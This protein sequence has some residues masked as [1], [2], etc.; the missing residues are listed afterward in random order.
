MFVKF[1]LKN[2]VLIDGKEGSGKT[3]FCREFIDNFLN[4]GWNVSLLAY[5]DYHEGDVVEFGERYE[6]KADLVV[7]VS[8]E[9]KE[10]ILD[11]LLSEQKQRLDIL[12]KRGVMR[13][14]LQIAVFDECGYFEGE[15][16][17]KLIKVLQNADICNQIILMTYQHKPPMTEAGKYFNTKIH[18]DYL[19][20]KPSS[21]TIDE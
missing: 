9:K 4:K 7:A 8:D 15:Q 2:R 6:G 18:V 21:V 19:T 12:N 5:A 11:I 16:R 20:H 3:W 13:E 10:N 14:S 17:E 1:K